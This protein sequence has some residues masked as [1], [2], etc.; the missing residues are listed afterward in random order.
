MEGERSWFYCP[1]REHWAPSSQRI[2]VPKGFKVRG[3]V[4]FF[5]CLSCAREIKR[6]R[7]KQ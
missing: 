3:Y 7:R 1:I 5:I 4:Y 2:K 6:R